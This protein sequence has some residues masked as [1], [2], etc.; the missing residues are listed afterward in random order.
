MWDFVKVW[1]RGR[2]RK[3]TVM[4][5]L[6]V[7]TIVAVVTLLAAGVAVLSRAPRLRAQAGE[8]PSI[9]TA[10]ACLEYGPLAGPT[11]FRVGAVEGHWV[12]VVSGNATIM[13]EGTWLNLEM[14]DLIRPSS[15]CR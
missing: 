5:K 1:H 15:L 7:L 8:V 11:A 10:G 14:R 2:I 13:K 9:V 6:R 4:P 12:S 3:E